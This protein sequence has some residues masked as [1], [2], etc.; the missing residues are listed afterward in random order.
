VI[1]TLDIPRGREA[2]GRA[3]RAI[4]QL[5][6]QLDDTTLQDLRLLI[7][8][9]VTNSVRHGEGEGI[10]VV[11]DVRGARHVRCE[12]VDGGSGFTPRARTKPPTEPGGWG[13]T[14][15]ERLSAAWGVREGSTHVWFELRR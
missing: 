14:M 7:S 5:Q 8:E 9:L 10:R 1:R 15:V 4:E 13:L 11:L 2:P 3:R 6:G 12:V